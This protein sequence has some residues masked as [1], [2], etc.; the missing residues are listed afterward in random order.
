[1]MIPAVEQLDQLSREDLLSLVRQLVQIIDQQ[2]QRIAALEAEIAKFRQPPPT[3]KNSSQPPA[4]D[5]KTDSS[6]NQKRKK[7]GPPFGHSKYSRPLVENP[8][9]VIQLPVTECESCLADLSKVVPE[10]FEQRQI[11]EL[12]SIRP[13]VIE[14]RRHLTTCPSCQKLN[15]APLPEGLEAERNF[16]PNLEAMVVYYKQVQHMSCERIVETM[17]ELHGVEL[18]EGG[19]MAILERAGKRAQPAAEQIKQ[20]VIAETV[21]KSDET[22]ARVKAKNWWRWVYISDAGVYHTIV[23]TRSA[24]EIKDV[25]GSLCVEVWV[26][27]CF[28]SQLKAPAK[29]FQLCLAHQLRDLQ[30]VIDAHPEE[31]WAIAMQSLFREAIHLRNREEEMTLMGLARRVTQIENRLDQLLDEPV[32]SDGALKLQNRY[33]THQNKLLTFLHYPEV[34]PTNNESERALRPSVVHRKVINGFRSGWGA[35]TYA[36]IQTIIATAKHK[37]ECVFESLV[38][39]MGTPVLPLLEDSSP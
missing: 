16:G 31:K 5:Q 21:I 19:V 35:K 26:C 38:K 24:E 32:E 34:P 17:R 29:V 22:S 30:R 33:L 10:D 15:R 27:D 3:S 8:D 25:M 13:I 23:P 12:P 7:H 14:T 9:R 36:A 39:L 28:S 37:G 2:Q 18:S 4:R 1:M 11:V 20:Q 6:S